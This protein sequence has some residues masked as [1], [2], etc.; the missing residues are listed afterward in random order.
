MKMKALLAILAILGLL[1]ACAE[2]SPHPM[3]MTAAVQSAK[4]RADHEALAEHYEQAAK[5]AEAKVEEHKKLLD[6]Y[7]ARS[8][9]YGKQASTFQTHCEAL[10][11]SYEQVATANSQMAKLHRDMAEGIQ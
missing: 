9:L 2:R 1:V 10:I 8:Y 11:R 4:T 7:K 6:R 5:D 3:D